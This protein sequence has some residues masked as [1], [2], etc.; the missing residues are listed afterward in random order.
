MMTKLYETTLTAISMK[1]FVGNMER[2]LR[3]FVARLYLFL[4]FYIP[5]IG[6]SPKPT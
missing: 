3:F 1:F 4:S 5:I 2:V 6:I